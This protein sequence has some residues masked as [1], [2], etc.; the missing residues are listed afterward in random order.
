[1]MALLTVF[2]IGVCVVLVALADM[3][4]PRATTPVSVGVG[5]V[6]KVVRGLTPQDSG[7]FF[8]FQGNRVQW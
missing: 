7:A 6:L 2:C 1:M 8:N 3:G 5:G 4:G